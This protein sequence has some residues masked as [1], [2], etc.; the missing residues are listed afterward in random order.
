[1]EIKGVNYR[2]SYDSSQVVVTLEGVLRL[3]P[4]DYQPLENLLDS[5]V[6]SGPKLVSLDLR[7]LSYMN[8]SGINVLY[9]F[10][11]L[12]RQ[13]ADMRLVVRAA[14]SIP[15]QN[16]SLPNLKSFNQDLELILGD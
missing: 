10:A 3:D 11:I 4:H 14:K 16:Q 2:V 1:M 13:H 8:S 9:K 5:V 12:T 7:A 6:A 15:W